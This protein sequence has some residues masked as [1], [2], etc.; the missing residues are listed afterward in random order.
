MGENPKTVFNWRLNY[1]KIKK[2]NYLSKE[3]LEKN[4]NL[5]FLKE[6]LLLLS[7]FN[8]QRRIS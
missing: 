8:R 3:K 2:N 6:I 7:S 1:E 5:N 4:S